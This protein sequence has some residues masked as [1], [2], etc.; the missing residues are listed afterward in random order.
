MRK[1]RTIA[2]LVVAL[3]LGLPASQPSDATT[4]GTN[5]AV[6]FLTA[7]TMTK[8]SDIDFGTV[9]NDSCTYTIS[10][11][12]A[13]TGSPGGTCAPLSGTTSAA[14]IT[15]AGSASQSVVISVAGYTAASTVTP[16]NA[17]CSY[18]G[19]AEGS[20]TITGA[21]PGAGKTL[22]IGVDVTT[23]GTETGGVAYQP[24]FT[25]TANYQ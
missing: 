18:N 16:S 5:M 2:A 12:G 23:A 25:V 24:T 22:L 19:G 8:N 11:T 3:S 15:I 21:A 20:C 10:T 4:L 7:V 17:K 13:V 1:V 6:S 14:N 9:K